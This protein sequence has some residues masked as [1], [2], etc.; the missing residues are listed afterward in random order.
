MKT[1]HTNR[2]MEKQTDKRFSDVWKKAQTDKRS[3][4]LK[5]VQMGRLEKYDQV[6][7]R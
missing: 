7:I 1:A 2:Q 3:G 5:V 4:D 6:I